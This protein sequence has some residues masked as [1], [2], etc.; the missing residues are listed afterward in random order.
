MQIQSVG[1][2]TGPDILSRKGLNTGDWALANSLEGLV[3][4]FLQSRSMD[5]PETVTF[6]T[7][8]K[9]GV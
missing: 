1:M 6:S 4:C 3:G 9:M 7:V 5:P 2:E 8:R